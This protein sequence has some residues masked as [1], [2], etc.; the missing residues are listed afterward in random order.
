MP[1]ALVGQ[2]LDVRITAGLIEVLHK[3][4]RVAS[5]PRQQTSGFSTLPEYMPKRHRQHRKWSPEPFLKKAKYI[6]PCTVQV[7]NH[8]LHNRPHPEHGYRACPGLLSHAR[9]YGKARLE[10]AC[11]RAQAI[12]SSTYRSVNLDA[13]N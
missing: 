7:V 5:H 1:H 3:G 6:G 8:Q 4:Q 9:R 12:D 11:D 2:V 10:A 13:Q